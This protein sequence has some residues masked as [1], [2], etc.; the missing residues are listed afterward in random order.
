MHQRGHPLKSDD[1]EEIGPIFPR[2]R[3]LFRYRRWL[4]KSEGI[5]LAVPFRAG[6]SSIGLCRRDGIIMVIRT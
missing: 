4:L 5:Q 2:N 6:L 1:T 3:S